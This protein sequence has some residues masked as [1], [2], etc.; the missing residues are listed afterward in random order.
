MKILIEN[1]EKIISTLIK[2]AR[3]L[4]INFLTAD[5]SFLSFNPSGVSSDSSRELV[6]SSATSLEENCSLHTGHS[7]F[8]SF[9]HLVIASIV[10]QC[11]HGKIATSSFS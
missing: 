4:N 2:I 9:N 3:L 8:C 6:F 10:K 5:P 7:A 11:L 1:F